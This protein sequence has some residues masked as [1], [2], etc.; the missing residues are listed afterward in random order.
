MSANM[1][2]VYGL[3]RHCNTPYE[4]DSVVGFYA[5]YTDVLDAAND[6]MRQ[7]TYE[8]EIWR[9]REWLGTDTTVIYED[10]VP[11]FEEW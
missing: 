3:Y 4:Q 1:K 11:N 6:G 2:P 7:S 8:G 9:I 5:H 10:S